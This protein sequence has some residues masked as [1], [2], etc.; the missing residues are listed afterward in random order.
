MK[1]LAAVLLVLAAA[2]EAAPIVEPSPPPGRLAAPP[3]EAWGYGGAL[4]RPW[5]PSLYENVLDAAV[6]LRDGS[7]LVLRQDSPRRS[8]PPPPGV[9]G[10]LF[11]QSTATLMRLD[12]QG[13]EVAR[14]HGS[15]PFGLRV[16]RVFEDLG[17]VIG[18][19]A[20]VRGGSIH[21]F[22]LKTLDGLWTM[23]DRDPLPCVQVADRCWT[24]RRSAAST[25]TT[26][27]TERDPRTYRALRTFHHLGM[28]RL[29]QAPG[30]YPAENTVVWNEPGPPTQRGVVRIERLE[31]DRP[32]AAW[33]ARV[34]TACW[35]HPTGPRHLY[36][37]FGSCVGDFPTSAELFDVASGRTVREWPGKE[38]PLMDGS[39]GILS[40][41]D[42]L[43]DL[44]DGS[45]G[46]TIPGRLLGVDA[47]RGVAATRLSNGGAAVYR[48]LGATPAP[49]PVAFREI[50][51]LTCAGFEFP[52][53]AAARDRDGRCP[54]IT[55]HAGSRR[56]LVT[57]GRT[58]G[59][60]ELTITAITADAVMRELTI[61][62]DVRGD[63][64]V[65][66]AAGVA[67][68]IELPDT[69]HG[70][71]LVRLDRGSGRLDLVDTF[72][73]DLPASA[74]GPTAT[75]AASSASPFPPRAVRANWGDS[76][77]TAA[78]IARRLELAGYSPRY[79]GQAPGQLLFGAEADEIYYVDE[80]R[81]SILLF[82]DVARA[83]EM[84][85]MLAAGR[86]TVTFYAPA[87]F[88]RIG[89]AVVIVLTRERNAGVPL[90]Q[91]LAN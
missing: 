61:G 56:L 42:A 40:W 47:E 55:V 35:A 13:R 48:R 16:L 87:H 27:L 34:D 41:H 46:G 77:T 63:Q 19:G 17:L 10:Q 24:Y 64:R 29:D 66:P 7:W 82:A 23:H 74:A 80:H 91:A 11:R 36:L 84:F 79:G 4:L 9:G 85:Q 39:T 20:Q 86:Y 88:I 30:I 25:D 5:D 58:R 51:R 15:E 70:E 43:V 59:A 89:R 62:I 72:V 37:G 2:C 50:A 6:T 32:A 21:A 44:R 3:V 1:A 8:V 28:D 26:A 60:E 12:A 49:M 31:L 33:A 54:E 90:V 38:A 78:D 65:V 68:I 67:R 75:S 73:I 53:V 69:L 45:R 76:D 52:Q 22:D 83:E 57:R 18:Y 14:E 81:V 71:W